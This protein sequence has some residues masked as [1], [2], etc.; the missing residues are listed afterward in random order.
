M[1]DLI[2]NF[3]RTINLFSFNT[4]GKCKKYIKRKKKTL[5][6]SCFI[7]TNRFNRNRFELTRVTFVNTCF[8][9]FS[10]ETPGV[11]LTWATITRQNHASDFSTC[12]FNLVS[13]W[14][15]SRPTTPT[16][17]SFTP[18]EHEN[19]TTNWTNQ[20]PLIPTEH[21]T[22]DWGVPPQKRLAKNMRAHTVREKA[23]AI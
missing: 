7:V 6:R 21:D 10:V 16:K 17:N 14:L 9:P 19:E 3:N 15:K 20:K 8:Q 22:D 2:R 12:R 4:K 11:V 23:S 5:Y 13:G 18:I 1:Y